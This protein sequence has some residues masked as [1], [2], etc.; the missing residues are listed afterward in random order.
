MA[1]QPGRLGNVIFEITVDNGP[2]VPFANVAHWDGVLGRIAILL[3]NLLS[4][5]ASD[6]RESHSI[7]GALAWGPAT[8]CGITEIAEPFKNIL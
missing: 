1:L 8:S 4:L 3:V 7:P 5:A 2:V 6:Y